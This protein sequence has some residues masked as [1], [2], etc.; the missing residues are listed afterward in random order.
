MSASDTRF[1]AAL[2]EMSVWRKES[3]E[4]MSAVSNL[5]KLRRPPGSAAGSERRASTVERSADAAE[6]DAPAVAGA[7]HEGEREM[8]VGASVPEGTAAAPSA[9]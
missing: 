6:L 9:V 5:I 3:S 8:L 2:L 4:A 7:S 1:A